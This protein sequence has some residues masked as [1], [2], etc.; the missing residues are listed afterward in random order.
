[1]PAPAPSR[2]IEVD[3]TLAY[4]LKLFGRLRVEWCVAGA[5]AANAY[6]SPRDTTDLD[7]VVQITAG[8]YPAIA[9]WSV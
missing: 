9:T 8:R 6:R 1:M 7:L 4:F 3:P 2:P 5:V